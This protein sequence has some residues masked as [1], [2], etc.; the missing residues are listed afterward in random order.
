MMTAEA[1]RA[2]GV[3]YTPRPIVDYIIKKTLVPLLEGSTPA[4]VEKLKIL[5][6]ACGSGCFLL[7]AYECLLSWHLD[8]YLS[9]SKPERFL[10]GPTAPLSQVAESRY[11]LSTHERKRILLN[12]LFGVDIDARAVEAARH[13]LLSTMFEGTS[14]RRSLPGLAHNIRCGNT[15]I[16]STHDALSGRRTVR[17]TARLKPFDWHD[18]KSGFGKILAAGGFDAIIGNPPY[19]RERDFKELLNE[20]ASSSFGRTYRRPRM[21]LWYYFVHRALEHLKESGRLSFIVNSYWTSGTGAEAL[22]EALRTRCHLEE[23]FLLGKA[24]VFDDVA[25]QHLIFVATRG[26]PGSATTVRCIPQDYAG[27]ARPY[28]E[29]L[30]P[31]LEY[32]KTHGELFHEGRIDLEPSSA[33]VLALVE[34]GQPLEELGLVRQ[35]IAENPSGINRRTNER[36]GTRWQVGEGVFVLSEAEFHALHLSASER[37]LARRYHDLGA[38]GRYW[39][40]QRPSRYLLYLTRDT[41]PDITKHPRL[42]QHLLRFKPLLEE[43]RETQSG[44]R[45][46]WQLHWPREPELWTQPKLLAIQMAERPSFAFVPGESYAPFS[47]NAFVPRPGTRLS[48][49]YLLG[50]LNSRLLWKW[51]LHRAKRRGIGLDI[52]GHVLREAPI[53]RIDF[54]NAYEAEQHERIC[55]LAQRIS[56]LHQ[57]LEGAASRQ[58]GLLQHQVEKVERQLDIAIY[59]LYGLDESQRATVDA[60][61]RGN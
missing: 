45:A 41:C 33:D 34:Q 61:T 15:L 4:R 13:A 25:G 43:R 27:S 12:N 16:D 58:H 35:G 53:R 5:D 21:D 40:S 48:P 54:D 60:Q 57:P 36:F 29:G 3:F 10:H 26:A 44:A 46:W 56:Q 52:N 42:H 55:A 23:F 37:R 19:R 2:G 6:P 14:A 38:L 22:I 18:T 59:D 31:V 47:V 17:A 39:A 11:V 8:W 28:V 50:V 49:Y 9:Q 24:R 7:P 30:T 51:F 32:Q 20:V 1:R